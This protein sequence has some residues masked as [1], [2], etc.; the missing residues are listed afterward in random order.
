MTEMSYSDQVRPHV[1]GEAR[2]RGILVLAVIG[3][4]VLSSGGFVLGMNV[5]LSP[6]WVVLAFGIAIA[7]GSVRAGLV[8]TIGSLWLINLWWFIFPPLV[9]YLT[10]SWGESTR[11]NYPR[12][13]GYAHGSAYDELIGGIESG[14]GA[15]LLFAL[16]VGVVG[17]STG[18][19]ISWFLTRPNPR[20]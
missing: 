5:G 2:N 17:Y 14:L 12:V 3:L 9:G 4:L 20:R 11:Y 13:L 8:P 6:G 19:A 7:A 16:L 10:G 18:A 15:G 1:V